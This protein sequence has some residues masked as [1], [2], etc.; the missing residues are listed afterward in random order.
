[1]L[2]PKDVLL[3]QKRLDKKAPPKPEPKKAP[4]PPKANKKP[5]PD[6]PPAA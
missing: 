2:S 6:L 1:M 5:P 3:F 4:E